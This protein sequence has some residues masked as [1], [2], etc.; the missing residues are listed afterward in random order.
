MARPLRIE[1]PG[2]VYHITS[3][4][5]GKDDIYLPNSD[6]ESFINVLLQVVERFDWVCYA[7][8]L[9]ANHY[10]LLIETPKGNLSKGMRHWNGVYT[11]RLNRQYSRVGHVFQGRYKAIL[12]EKDSHLL[13]LC[14]YIVRNPVAAGMV[15]NVGEWP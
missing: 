4:G 10:H 14:R 11:Q 3:R 9:M 7:W 12:V 1:F 5:D 8:C 13:K 2:A 6:R 15:E